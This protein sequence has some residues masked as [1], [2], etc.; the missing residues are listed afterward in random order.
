VDENIS[1]Q[2]MNKLEEA[3]HTVINTIALG[4]AGSEDRWVLTRAVRERTIILTSDREFSYFL[5]FPGEDNPPPQ[6]LLIPAEHCI[7]SSLM[8]EVVIALEVL[9]SKLGDTPFGAKLVEGQI[10]IRTGISTGA[11]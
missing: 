5:Q 8:E 3:G 6:A 7:N 10:S 2:L 11:K 9:Q 4:L 1:V